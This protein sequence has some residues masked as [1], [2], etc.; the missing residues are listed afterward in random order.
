MRDIKVLP[1]YWEVM[2]I[3]RTVGDSGSGLTQ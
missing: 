3:T 1:P 2:F